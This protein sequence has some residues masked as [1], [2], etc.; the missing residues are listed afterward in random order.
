[1]NT[2]NFPAKVN[3]RRERAL[4]RLNNPG[5]ESKLTLAERH[6]LANQVAMKLNASARSIRTKKDRSSGARFAR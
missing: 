6:D 4:E 5:D 3:A 1:M 2:A